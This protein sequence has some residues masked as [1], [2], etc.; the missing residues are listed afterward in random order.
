MLY[1]VLRLSAFHLIAI[2]QCAI[3][4]WSFGKTF[5]IYGNMYSKEKYM[6][7]YKKL[8]MH[9]VYDPGYQ[10]FSHFAL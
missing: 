8:V 2:L 5:H 6:Y 7:S 4:D 3:C 9:G 10:R 1:C